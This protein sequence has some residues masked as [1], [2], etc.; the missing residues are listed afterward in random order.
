MSIY[1]AL[2]ERYR[3]LGLDEGEAREAATTIHF[4]SLEDEEYYEYENEILVPGY[5]D[6]D[7][8]DEGDNDR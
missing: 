6:D 7:D 5:D 3:D 1:E 8:D 2:I 4:Y